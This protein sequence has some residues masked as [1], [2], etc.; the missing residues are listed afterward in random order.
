VAR[1]PLQA[2]RKRWALEQ[3]NIIARRATQTR[4]S[5][6]ASCRSRLRSGPSP[7]APPSPLTWKAKGRLFLHLHEQLTTPP[8]GRG[9]VEVTLLSRG[10]PFVGF[11]GLAAKVL[12][13][14]EP[15]AD[16]APRLP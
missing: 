11:L 2:E 16:G 12:P 7:A 6:V 10:L 9:I 1:A 14:R 4:L 15:D 3:D 8:A 5:A 13:N